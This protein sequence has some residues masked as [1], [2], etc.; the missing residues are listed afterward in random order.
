MKQ[1]IIKTCKAAHIEF[2]RI[3]SIRQY[4][5][6]DV[7]KTLVDWC[8]LSRL[9]FWNS[10]LVGY[11]HAQSSN[12]C[13]KYRPL[14]P[15]SSLNLVE[16]NRLNLLKLR[17]MVHGCMVYTER[18]ETATVSRGT[19]HVKTKQRSKYTSSVAIVKTRY[20]KRHALTHLESQAT[21]AQ[22]VC[23]RAENSVT[24]KIERH[25]LFPS[26]CIGSP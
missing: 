3:S 24:Q 26:N 23:S 12:H 21:N 19:S 13:S 25:H 15:N 4:L 6:E 7:T 10:L 16:K 9:D 20:E 1:R 5:T 22:R 2:R 18:A 8:I 14:R 11:R 17:D